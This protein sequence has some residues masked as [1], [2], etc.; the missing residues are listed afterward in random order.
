MSKILC[1][2]TSPIAVASSEQTRCNKDAAPHDI[3]CAIYGAHKVQID[4]YLPSTQP[5]RMLIVS[6]IKMANSIAAKKT[7]PLMKAVVKLT[8]EVSHIII[9]AANS[10]SVF[11]IDVKFN[12]AVQ[13]YAEEVIAEM[14]KIYNA[15]EW[16]LFW[17]AREKILAATRPVAPPAPPS[18]RPSVIDPIMKAEI[19][20]IVNEALRNALGNLNRNA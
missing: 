18:T 15:E 6:A 13:Q 10:S 3:V 19:I 20:Q 16:R 5:L 2:G 8:D 1:L 11:N 17:A 14:D 12:A 9:K 4:G 7:S